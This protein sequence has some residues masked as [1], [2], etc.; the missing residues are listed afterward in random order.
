MNFDEKFNELMFKFDIDRHCPNYRKCVK[1]IALAKNLYSSMKIQ[2]EEFL[3]LA[4]DE[5]D[6]RA[7]LA[8]IGSEDNCQMK[9]YADVADIQPNTNVLLVS[10]YQKDEIVVK[11]LERCVKVTSLYDF[12]EEKGL[13]F[14]HNFYDVYNEQ[15]WDCDQKKWAYE[16]GDIDVNRI[17]FYHRK[18][19]E[20]EE[21]VEI[22]KLYLEKMIFDCAYVKDFLT[23][24]ENIDTYT[25]A[26]GDRAEK[27]LLFYQEIEALLD[28][29]KK[30]LEARGTEDCILFWLDAIEY[31]MDATMPFLKELDEKALVFEKAFT[32]TPY[33]SPTFL[34]FLTGKLQIEDETYRIKQIGEKDSILVRELRK[35]G[36]RF[37]YYGSHINHLA[38]PALLANHFYGSD[39]YS[40]TQLYWDV[41]TDMID[42]AGECNSFCILHELMQTHSPFV[43]FGLEGIEYL[44]DYQRGW[45]KAKDGQLLTRRKKQQMESRIYVDRQL[46]FWS[47]MLPEKMYKI[48]M[49]DHGNTHVGRYHTIMKV[50]QKDICPGVCNSLVSYANFVPLV[51]QLLDD[52]TIDENVISGQYALIQEVAWYNKDRVLEAVSDKDFCSIHPDT[53]LG[54]QGVVTGEDMLI[55]YANG[56]EY[57]LKHTNDYKMVTDSRLNYLRGL[58]SKKKPDYFHIDKFRYTRILIT[59]E[60]RC[61]ER[62]QNIRIRKWEVIEEIFDRIRDEEVLALRGGGFHTL[63]LLMP[64]KEQYR[65]KVKY[66][67]DGDRECVGGKMGIEV[68]TL[69]ELLQKGVTTVLISSYEHLQE[70]EQQLSVY[71]GIRIINIYKILEENGFPCDREFCFEK[72][73]DEDFD[74]SLAEV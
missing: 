60:Q 68:I 13:E 69:E 6:I 31:G 37:K 73:R 49:S 58:V 28:E 56:L 63:H 38:D 34:T 61:A 57:Y 30:A 74:L 52:R 24:K 71:K 47:K 14:N 9:Y 43:S 48:Y 22:K 62:T 42:D 17:Y 65:N 39:Y 27:Y 70:W 40:F 5:T 19:Y 3:L 64:L 46:A 8:C 18:R 53:Y 2:G 23:L 54:Y 45:L 25:F 66:I 55:C 72:F 59:A 16:Y 11:L 12:F 41:L 15:Y 1:A 32:V 35:R 44:K 67:I 51:L 21:K 50:Q 10:Y 33:T 36:Y 20:L 7:F 29:L 26:F 4:I